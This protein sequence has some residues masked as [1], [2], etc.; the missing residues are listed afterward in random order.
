MTMY[1]LRTALIAISTIGLLVRPGAGAAQT[2]P[3]AQSQP[4][5]VGDLVDVSEDF[6]KP[7]QLHFVGRRV[8]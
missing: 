5:I 2:A 6:E 7:D 1:D 3:H 4:Q 8:T